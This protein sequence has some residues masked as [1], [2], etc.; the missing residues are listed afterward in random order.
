[1]SIYSYF[2]FNRMFTDGLDSEIG[3]ASE[4]VDTNAYRKH[5]KEKARE[6][7]RRRMAEIT[8]NGSKR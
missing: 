4:T 5:R 8:N 1:M 6:L 7:T 2:G 3:K